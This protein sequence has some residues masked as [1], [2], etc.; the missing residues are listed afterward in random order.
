[1]ANEFQG[2]DGKTYRWVDADTFT[3]GE[4]SYRIQGYNAPEKSKVIRDDEGK[5]RFKTGQAGGEEVQ[6]VV[7]QM[8]SAGNF[9]DIEDLGITDSFGRKRV[10][11]RNSEGQDLTNEL[12]AS[13]AI[14]VNRFTDEEGLRADQR[15]RFLREINAKQ[16]YDGIIGEELSEIQNQP[17]RF[18][19]TALNEQEYLNGVVETIAMQQGLDLTNEEDRRIAM[20]YAFDANYDMR[21]IPFSGIDFRAQDRTKEGVAYN[22]TAE[23]WNQGWAGM[24]VGLAGFAELAG[25]GIGSEVIETWGRNKV[26]SAKADLLDAPVIRNL[27]YRDVDSVWDGLDFMMNN[28]AM[29]A[30]YMTTLV[31][32]TLLAPVTGGASVAIAYGST[33]ASYAGQVWNDIEGSKGR[34]EAAGSLMA[35]TAMAVLDRLGMNQIMKP[36]QLLTQKGRLELIKG[37]KATKGVTS[38]EAYEMFNKATKAEVKALISGL[39]NFAS[40]NINN[41]QVMRELLKGAGRGT[42]AESVTEAAQEGTG[43]LSSAAMSEGGLKENFNPNEFQNLLAQSAIAG[44]TIGG[45]L[46]VAGQTIEAGDR[47]AMQ[48]GFMLGNTSGLNAYDEIVADFGEAGSV[49]N[50]ITEAS[51]NTEGYELGSQ[52]SRTKQ[53]AGAGEKAR[54]SFFDKLKDPTKY[55]ELFRTS[56]TSGFPPELLRQSKAL[57]KLYALTGQ[58]FGKLYSG[59]D[60][61]AEESIIRGQLGSLFNPEVVF[62]RFG[63]NENQTN[64]NRISDMIRRAYPNLTFQRDPNTGLI[65]GAT[66]KNQGD[67]EIVNNLD[68]IIETIRELEMLNSESHRFRNLAY[69]GQDA[70]RAE[71]GQGLP[72]DSLGWLNTGAW[73]WS[74]VRNNREEWYAWM[75][76][77]TEYG[78]PENKEALDVLYTKVSNNEDASDFSLVEGVEY[79]PGRSLGNENF[80]AIPGFEKFANT[81]VIQ[82]AMNNVAETAKY[83]AYTTYF[84]AGG[85]HID[86]LLDEAAKEGVS[87]EDLN[88]VAHFTKSIIDAG[89]GNY[90]PITNRKLAFMQRQAAF[91]S[92]MVGLPMA[93]ISSFPEF[94]MAVYQARDMKDVRNAVNAATG[95]LVDIMKKISVMDMHDSLRNVPRAHVDNKAQQRLNKVGHLRDS[96]GVATRLGMGE[97]DITTAWYQKQ[98]YK[99]SGIAGLTNFQR[100]ISAS[101]ATSFISD[102]IRMLSANMDDAGRKIDPKKL[103]QDKLEVYMQLKNLGIDVDN[104]VRIYNKYNGN[105]KMFDSFMD[106]NYDP[107]IN[108]DS[109]FIDDQ[110]TTATWYFVNDRVQNP[111]AYNR[112]L[113]FQDPRFQLLVQFNGFMSTFTANIVPR[114]WN[115][116]VRK[117]SPR[118]KYNTFAMMVTMMAFAGASQWL[119]DFIKFGG[120]TPYLNNYQLMQRAIQSAG[121]LGTGE[122]ILQMG[123]PM[124]SSRDQGLVDRVFGETI[125]G[126]P[127]LRNVATGTKAVTALSQGETERA[128]G[129]TLKLVPGIGPF[130]PIRNWIND[131]VHGIKGD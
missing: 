69:V 54:G 97:T 46:G 67:V 130:T 21:S 105:Q 100:A 60:V 37:L 85:K 91:Y 120:S 83:S 76:A 93:A 35:G 7:E 12:Y 36:S 92:A 63:F 14:D 81:N 87:E 115:D 102:R 40:D 45:A 3:D 52:K 24:G 31:G 106:D 27:D 39:N 55:P 48:K 17:I 19:D 41:S 9:N 32:G 56:S 126:S 16:E 53:R 107:D 113:F 20:N 23:A 51:V 99:W 66:L 30:P 64:S 110:M 8:V 104:T 62:K 77:N 72:F 1:M 84:G 28:V 89:T 98:F 59:R 5:L 78:K 11:L 70:K 118:M 94:V 49:N 88:H 131:S 57:R 61:Q 74:K 122:R 109:Q 119:K 96:A 114:L 112:P 127:T 80:A 29:S 44:G 50:I 68:A 111:Q 38:K 129:H 13:G 125:G 15:G 33:G 101:L 58:P 18:K 116:Y 71:E 75:R 26:E 4:E 128:L 124:Y 42:L 117:G 34:A 103:S 65:T 73:D 82:N 2:S 86:Y 25:V 10:R 6:N 79:V 43:Y 95:E 22:Q 47:Y 123:L 108:R 121:L 90:K